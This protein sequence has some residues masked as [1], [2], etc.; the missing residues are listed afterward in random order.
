MFAKYKKECKK[1]SDSSNDE[2]T[3]VLFI[4]YYF[5]LDSSSCKRLLMYS[6]LEE[7]LERLKRHYGD[8][9]GKR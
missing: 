7:K 6:P 3:Y 2:G 5:L 8:N 4:N 9:E 1:L